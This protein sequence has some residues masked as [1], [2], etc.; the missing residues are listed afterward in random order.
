MFAVSPDWLNI[1]LYLFIAVPTDWLNIVRVSCF[2]FVFTVRHSN[3]ICSAT[4]HSHDT[5][6]PGSNTTFESSPQGC[7]L[8]YSDSGFY[9]N[10]VRETRNQFR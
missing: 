10:F 2:V 1:V 6:I 8:H 7:K 4:F 3:E 5:Y 9:T